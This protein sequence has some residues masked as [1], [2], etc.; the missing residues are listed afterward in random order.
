MH[1]RPLTWLDNA[2]TTQ[3]PHAVIDRLVHFYEHENAN[4]HRSG[5]T[6]GTRA[7]GAYEQARATVARFINAPGADSVVFVRGTTEAANLVAQSWGREYVAE[8][9]EI[10]VSWLDTAPTLCHGSGWHARSAR[11]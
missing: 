9:D 4:V 7:T 2:A 10:V 3:K 11:R 8:G 1:G 5:H 6:L